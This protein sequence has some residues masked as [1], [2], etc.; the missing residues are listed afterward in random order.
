MTCDMCGA[1]PPA[2]VCLMHQRRS[3]RKGDAPLFLYLC[4]E[5][6]ETS[7][8]AVKL[9]NPIRDTEGGVR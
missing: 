1:A 2:W 8:D 3:G 7:G 4:D 5:C 6:R 9:A